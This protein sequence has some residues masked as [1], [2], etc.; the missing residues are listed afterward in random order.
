MNNRQ[1]KNKILTLSSSLLVLASSVSL[2]IYLSGDIE[3]SF[4]RDIYSI[5]L[6]GDV[7]KKHVETLESAI[8][9]ST[10]ISTSLKKT[11]AKIETILLQD[12]QEYIEDIRPLFEPE[13]FKT[14]SKDLEVK[15]KFFLDSDVRVVSFVVTEPPILVGVDV[16]QPTPH[17]LFH[18]K[19]QYMREG[20]F[21]KRS[22]DSTFGEI[23]IWVTIKESI[24][25]NGN[26]SG[27]EIVNYETQ[28]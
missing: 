26:P 18:I 6:S 13:F 25:Q 7:E 19:G 17:W 4:K 14:F 9:T 22:D 2:S 11:V 16:S 3:K 21:E 15:S 20:L 28:K 12:V 23:S 5:T 24:G 27:I 8:L 1:I 10:T